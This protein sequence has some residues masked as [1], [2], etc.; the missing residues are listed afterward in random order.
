MESNR[1]NYN[2][3]HFLILTVKNCMQYMD[4][5]KAAKCA[6]CCIL[7]DAPSAP[8]AARTWPYPSMRARLPSL[9][10]LSIPPLSSVRVVSPV[11]RVQ[12]VQSVPRLY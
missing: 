11:A 5:G 12:S 6:R 1:N 2:H 9:Y 4:A 7:R 10:Q 8:H 3:A